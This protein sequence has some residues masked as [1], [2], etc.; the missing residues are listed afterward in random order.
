MRSPGRPPI[1]RDV[2]RAFWTKI[3]EGLTSEDAAVACGVSGPVGSRWFRDRGGM[4]S[5]EL[6]PP[7]G[8]YL[9]FTEREE[10]ALLKAQKAGVREI[11]RQLGR[12]P[13]TISRELRR[14]AATRGAQLDYRASIA[15][16]KAELA[17]RRP[18]TSKLAADERLREYVQEHLAGRVQAPDGTPVN[19]PVVEWKGRNKPHRQDRRWATA[20]SPEQ[21]ANRL[22]LDHPDDESMRISHEAIYQA[23]YIRGRGALEREYV[24]CLRTGRALRVPRARSRRR[25]SGHVTPEV[26]ISERPAEAETRTVAGHWEGDLIIGTNRSAIGTLVERTTR[27]TV[28]V[29]LPRMEGYGLEPRTKN[30]P[31][32]GGY[33]AEAMRKALTSRMAELP[34]QLR[35]TLT[36]DRGKEL[37]QHAQLKSD[38]GMAV[39]FADP[40]SPWQRGTNE[41]TNGLLRQFF[42]KGTDLSR[43][44]SKELEAVA[45][46]LNTRPR[47][48][49]AWRTP[50][51]ALDDELL[52]LQASGV[53]TTP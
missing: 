46:T 23:L 16:W 40:H 47:K 52:S 28:L 2:E 39:Y 53:A 13:S 5:I 32:L 41:N 11:A 24:A 3:A 37:A 43:W 9:S 26:M 27:F 38:T 35:R 21:I 48:T 51:E 29:H 19:G 36:W 18:K 25:P 1:R 22:P 33:G 6:S 34:G 44:G 17:A 10:I 8:R 45:R 50:T 20:W 7:S 12:S 31:A 30:G 49:L 15:Q 4:P 42:P 14:N